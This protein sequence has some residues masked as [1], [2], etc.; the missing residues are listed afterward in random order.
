M[1]LKS[2]SEFTDTELSDGTFQMKLIGI[3]NTPH[4]V[5]MLLRR[6]GMHPKFSPRI[7]STI[8]LNS[9]RDRFED[10]RVF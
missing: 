5:A 9:T 2:N 6:L 8:R 10:M 3:V 7:N 1:I 4:L